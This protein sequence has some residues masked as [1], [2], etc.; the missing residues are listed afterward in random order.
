MG[1][2][3]FLTGWHLS[4]KPTKPAQVITH[5]LEWTKSAEISKAVLATAGYR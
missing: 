4:R 1:L 2:Q 3:P 5:L